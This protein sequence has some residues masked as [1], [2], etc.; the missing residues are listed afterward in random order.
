MHYE[1]CT[2]KYCPVLERFHEALPFIFNYN[3]FSVVI[4]QPQLFCVLLPFAIYSYLLE[5]IFSDF[6]R[7]C[8]N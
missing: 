5:L 3:I 1:L 6:I 4:F 8:S 2:I 7:C